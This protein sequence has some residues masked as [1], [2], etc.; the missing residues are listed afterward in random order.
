M[1]KSLHPDYIWAGNLF[2][3]SLSGQRYLYCLSEIVPFWDTF[4][5]FLARYIHFTISKVGHSQIG[6]SGIFVPDKLHRNKLPRTMTIWQD[7]LIPLPKQRLKSGSLWL[8]SRQFEVP[9]SMPHPA[10]Y[11]SFQF[12]NARRRRKRLI[13]K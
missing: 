9:K 11:E 3:C 5:E 4:F 12:P 1:I 2:L 13:S 6:N 10:S 8:D 7:F